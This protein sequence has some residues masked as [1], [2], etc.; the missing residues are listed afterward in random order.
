M[1]NQN[2]LDKIDE[3]ALSKTVSSETTE[4][5]HLDEY[6]T[7]GKTSYRLDKNQL[8]EDGQIKDLVTFMLRRFC[9]GHV[10][11]FDKTN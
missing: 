1:T 8:I 4:V 6:V 2:P 7:K 9:C 10:C 11:N 5:I 3:Q